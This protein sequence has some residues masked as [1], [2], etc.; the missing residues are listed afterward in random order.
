M[1]EGEDERS[2]EDHVAAL[3]RQ[4]ERQ[5]DNEILMMVALYNLMAYI[6]MPIDDRTRSINTSAACRR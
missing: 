6:G 1:I 4:M 5:V 2:P 3:K